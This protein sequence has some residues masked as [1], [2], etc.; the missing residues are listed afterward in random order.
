MPMRRKKLS[1]SVFIA[2]APKLM[3]ARA[4]QPTG[5]V[6]RNGKK[7]EPRTSQCGEQD[8]LKIKCFDFVYMRIAFDLGKF[9]P[10]DVCVSWGEDCF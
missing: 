2:P 10:G 5:N 4:S 9:V 7:T 3:P 1:E 6:L 8:L